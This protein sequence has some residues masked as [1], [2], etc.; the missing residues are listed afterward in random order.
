[1]DEF[2][3]LFFQDFRN[4]LFIYHY[5]EHKFNWTY[6]KLKILNESCEWGQLRKTVFSER[7]LTQVKKKL[8]R[9]T[10]VNDIYTYK[11]TKIKIN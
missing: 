2:D 7:N 4:Y 1:M 11:H 10:D 9:L 5:S 6:Q 3:F 8:S